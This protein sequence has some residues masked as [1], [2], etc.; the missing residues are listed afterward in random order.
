[1]RFV[2]FVLLGLATWVVTEFSHFNFKFN[3]FILPGLGKMLL[4]KASLE[5]E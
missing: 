4:M 1:M 2:V 3:N 5:H